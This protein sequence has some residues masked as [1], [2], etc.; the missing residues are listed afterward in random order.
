MGRYRWIAIILFLDE[1]EE[2][3][4]ISVAIKSGSMVSNYIIYYI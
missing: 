1:F 3:A 4:N 2:D